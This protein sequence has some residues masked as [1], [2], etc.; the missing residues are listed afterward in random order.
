MTFELYTDWFKAAGC[1]LS[2]YI[3]HFHFE[4]KAV[5]VLNEYFIYEFIYE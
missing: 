3:T 5:G 1:V 2:P 4:F